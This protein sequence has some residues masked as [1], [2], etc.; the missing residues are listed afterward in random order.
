MGA[1]LHWVEPVTRRRE[2]ISGSRSEWQRTWAV[3]PCR[4]NYGL[5][6][7]SAHQ[8]P[9]SGRTCTWP[10]RSLGICLCDVG[11][12]R[13]GEEPRSVPDLASHP[14][15]LEPLFLPVLMAPT[16]QTYCKPVSKLD[17]GPHRGPSSQ[18]PTQNP[19]WT[20]SLLQG[21]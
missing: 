2:R 19:P 3:V 18:L 14:D 13:F 7:R 1:H 21:V 4:R 5:T 8:Q 17:P 12:P 16:P 6:S 11:G 20:G 10:A 15:N 9:V